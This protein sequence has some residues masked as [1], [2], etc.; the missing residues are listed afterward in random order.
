MTLHRR[1]GKLERA[2][3]DGEG[4]RGMVVVSPRDG[5]TP[6]DVLNRYGLTWDDITR[7]GT[8]VFVLPG[9]FGSPFADACAGDGS[10]GVLL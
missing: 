10:D 6:D 4:F 9:L 7:D 2:R 8:G 3:T 5:E 1:I